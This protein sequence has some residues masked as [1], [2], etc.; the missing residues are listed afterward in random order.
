MRKLALIPFLMLAV[1]AFAQDTPS[2]KEIMLGKK[3]FFAIAESIRTEIK[4]TEDQK[5]KIMD[6]FGDTLRVDG[7]KIMLM[8]TPDTD[9]K[10]LEKDA[11][12]VLNEEQKKR[13]QEVWIQRL[14]GVALGD[15]DVAK[16]V[17]LTD[18]Q[19]ESVEK[20]LDT[21]GDKMMEIFSAGHDEAA[22]K[23]SEKVRKD[24]AKQ[25]EALLTEDQ[26]KAFEAM[27]GKLMKEK[28]DGAST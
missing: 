4:M 8:M 1:N 28:K 15:D 16:A 27:K 13:L 17:K 25:C 24:T 14:G 12:A 21:G 20:L 11:M 5:K 9:M 6:V 19:K 2:G 26:K 7:E 18:A 3:V 23:E 10:Q 22:L